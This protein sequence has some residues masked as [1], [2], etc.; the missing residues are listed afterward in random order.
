MI[1]Q[2]PRTAGGRPHLP[3]APALWSWLA[4]MTKP[5]TRGRP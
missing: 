4:V 2:D 1:L 3:P 5:T